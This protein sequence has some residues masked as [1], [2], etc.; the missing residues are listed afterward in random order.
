MRYFSDRRPTTMPGTMFHRVIALFA[1]A[2][3]LLAGCS[4]PQAPEPEKALPETSAKIE[5]PVPSGPHAIG[6]IDFE[7]VDVSRDE[8]FAP[9]TPR[10]I[11]VRA[12][13]PAESVSGTPRQYVS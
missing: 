10:R 2:T 3:L 5:L 9:G 11:P 13:Y 1:A 7:L 8:T 4:E 6:V 12:W